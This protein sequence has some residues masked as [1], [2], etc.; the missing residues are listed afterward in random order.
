MKRTMAGAKRTLLRQ[1]PGM[2]IFGLWKRRV[3]RHQEL[4][5]LRDEM[6]M[7]NALRHAQEGHAVLRA[8]LRS[9]MGIGEQ[10]ITTRSH[11]AALSLTQAL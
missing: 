3:R 7:E 1:A 10:V 11:C 9:M 2:E 5:A 4:R 6:G 8:N